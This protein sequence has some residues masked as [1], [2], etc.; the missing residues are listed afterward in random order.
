VAS[1]SEQ[2]S[3]NVQTVAAAAE[4]LSSSIGEISRQVSHSTEIATTAVADAN[5]AQEVVSE[6]ATMVQ[7]IDDVVKLI[8][9]I[10][11]QTNLLALNATIEAARA[12]DAGKGFAVVAN[13]VKNLATQTAKAT[14]DIGRQIAS[15]Q[16]QTGKVVV[17]IRDI[18]AVIEEIGQV[19]ASIAAAVEEQTAATNSIAANVDQAAMGTAEVS[20]NVR[21]V[22]QA[23]TEAGAASAEVLAASRTLSTGSSNLKTLIDSFLQD[24]RGT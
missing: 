5:Q 11:S 16:G 20:G 18:V 12:G 13:E 17:T 3:I 2:A 9:N 14:E 6:L 23:A 22:L 8:N 7:R 10:A 19:S 15:V 4:H 24:V 1:A 21:G